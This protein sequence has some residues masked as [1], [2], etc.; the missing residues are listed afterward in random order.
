MGER[1]YGFICKTSSAAIVEE[2][3][4]ATGGGKIQHV[5]M[6]MGEIDELGRWKREKQRGNGMAIGERS[7]DKEQW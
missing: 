2:R 3:H 7:K 1:I 6:G 5:I 4:K